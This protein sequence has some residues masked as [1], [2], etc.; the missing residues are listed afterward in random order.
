MGQIIDEK[1]AAKAQEEKKIH[2]HGNRLRKQFAVTV[3]EILQDLASRTNSNRAIVF[4]FSNGTSNLVGLPF[5]FMTAAAEVAT[6]GLSLMSQTHQRLNTSVIA[7][8]LAKLEKEGS[9]FIDGTS[10]MLEEYKILE[11]IM[12]GAGMKSALFYSIQG[13]EEAIGFLVIIT[14]KNSGNTID[15]S[16]ATFWM[17]RAAQRIS[18]MINF[19]EMDEIEKKTHK[20]K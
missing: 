4:E 15:L 18:S 10:P 1:F 20:W 5:M 2:L 3:Q 8:F 16:T 17:N 11:Q 14:T 12:Q 19:D 7:G 9:I 13:I 6:P